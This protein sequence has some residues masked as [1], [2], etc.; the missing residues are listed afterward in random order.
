MSES[1]SHS[2]PSTFTFFTFSALLKP[3]MA[4]DQAGLHLGHHVGVLGQLGH[5]EVAQPVAG[6]AH[7][8][9]LVGV[10]D[11]QGGDEGPR[12]PTAQAWPTS[13]MDLSSASRLAGL[14]FLPPAVMISSFLRS[15]TLEVAV[16]VDLADVAGVQPAVV[17]EGLGRL[18][19]LRRG[20]P[21][22]PARPGR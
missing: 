19:G 18:L 14:M 15:T 8:R 7:A 21:G 12:S 6:S 13:G 20:S 4:V 1:G 2:S 5:G 17:V 10:E 3:A 22:R 9:G 11:D 16:F